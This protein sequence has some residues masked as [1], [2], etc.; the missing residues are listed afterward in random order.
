MTEADVFES[1]VDPTMP[2]GTR[3]NIGEAFTGV[4]RPL[5]WTAVGIPCDRGI[6]QLMRDLGMMKNDPPGSWAMRLHRGRAYINLSWAHWQLDGRL[7]GARPSDL[8]LGL[9]QDRDMQVTRPPRPSSAER[10]IKAPFVVRAVAHVVRAIRRSDRWLEEARAEWAALSLDGAKDSDLVDEL[11]RL[12]KD[13][14][15]A[16]A[17]HSRTSLGS[18]AVFALL[19]RTLEKV[20]SPA[21]DSV[22]THLMSN[23]GRVESA[24][25]TIELRKLAA[26]VRSRAANVI[27]KVQEQSP[28]HAVTILRQGA[29]EFADRFDA[30]VARYGYRSGTE[31]MVTA[32]SWREDPG[33]LVVSLYGMLSHGEARDANDGTPSRDIHVALADIPAWVRPLARTLWAWARA[34]VRAREATKALMIIRVDAIRK[35]VRE[36]ARRLATAGHVDDERDVSLL[37][38]DE[39][40]AALLGKPVDL[41]R[42][43]ADRKAAVKTLENEPNPPLFI[44]G[45]EP[46]DWQ[47]GDND[48]REIQG[49]GVSAGVVEGRV[50]VAKG[51]DDLVDLEDG[52]IIVAPYT[53]AGWTPYFAIAE[54]I[55]IETGGL[56]S[57]CAVVARELGVPAV[58]NAR[59]VLDRV[60]SG[61]WLRLDGSTGAVEIL[62]REGPEHVHPSR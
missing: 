34:G 56:M 40:E 14:E 33:P 11:R 1:P 7:P 37:T 39:L 17:E 62:R 3:V 15:S 21:D 38:V 4:V 45:A 47:L 6:R 27:P 8:A 23:V 22:L 48:Q 49:I 9:S 44:D 61:D 59:D 51:L 20:G 29:P 58:V 25:P 28:R 32:P 12:R 2:I 55:V 52:Q 36:A 5:D 50:C 13:L 42:I 26:E 18:S 24:A 31:F 46:L 41:R 54:G 10:I 16:N 60:K 57:H 35:C 30:I 43:V 53:D 19:C